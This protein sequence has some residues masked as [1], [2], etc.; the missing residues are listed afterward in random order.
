MI[1]NNNVTIKLEKAK[2]GSHW[3]Q[4]I[5]KEDKFKAEDLPKD[6]A[7]DPSAGLM[8]MMKK[9]YEDGDEN[10]KRTIAE[11]WTKSKDGKSTGKDF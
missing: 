2:K 7:K 6:A 8:D 10:M 11:A 9:M 4:L 3:A 1:N 5:K